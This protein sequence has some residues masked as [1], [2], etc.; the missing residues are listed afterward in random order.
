MLTKPNLKDTWQEISESVRKS[1]VTKDNKDGNKNWAT[2]AK[3][4]SSTVYHMALDKLRGQVFHK[5]A[6]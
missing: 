6:T 2:S 1:E 5:F 4:Y 3:G